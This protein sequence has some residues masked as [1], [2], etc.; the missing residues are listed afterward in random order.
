MHARTI[1]AL[2]L[3]LALVFFAPVQAPAAESQKGFDAH[4][5][6]FNYFFQDGD[7]D[8]HFGNLVLGSAVNNGVSIGEAFYAA[9]HIK[10][11]DAASWQKQWFELAERARTRGEKSLAEGHKASAIDQ[12]QRAAYYYRISL[13][14][15]LPDDSRLTERA[16]L[17]RNTLLKAGKLL[18]PVVEYFEIPFE[19][20]VLPGFLP[21][22]GPWSRAGQDPDHAGRRRDIR[23]GTCYYYIMPQA[24]ARGYNFVTLDL[25]GQGLLPMK[26]KVFRPDMKRAHEDRG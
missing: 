17:S 25:P 23:R 4:A 5:S 22:G 1:L 7:M 19:G 20:G 2:G 24:H 26:G 9:S 16:A 10:D 14:G 13:I 18:D 11:G 21:Q 3:W 12:L 8:F 6:D 15:I